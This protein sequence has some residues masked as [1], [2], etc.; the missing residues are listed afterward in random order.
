MG[1]ALKGPFCVD[2][3]PTRF[4]GPTTIRQT[5][6]GDDVKKYCETALTTFVAVAV[7]LSMLANVHASEIQQARA[8]P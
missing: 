1:L 7:S 5:L 3:M 2:T 8:E 4:S 6:Q